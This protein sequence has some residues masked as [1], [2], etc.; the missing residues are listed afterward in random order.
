[1]M[2][3][4]LFLLIYNCG[5][6]IARFNDPSYYMIK[7]VKIKKLESFQNFNILASGA[8]K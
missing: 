6:E 8:K 1:M 3:I 5:V 2:Q 4:I 7:E